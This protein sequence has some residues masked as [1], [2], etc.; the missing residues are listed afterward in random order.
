[1]IKGLTQGEI[2][3]R[4]GNHQPNVSAWLSGKRIPS[5]QSLVDL[6][7]AMEMEPDELIAMIYRRRQR[8]KAQR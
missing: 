2:A 6:A 7:R 8:L 1:M 4:M 3:R 5:E